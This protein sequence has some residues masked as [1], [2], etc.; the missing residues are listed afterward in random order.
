MLS[1]NISKY[2]LDIQYSEREFQV[3]YIEKILH[4][5]ANI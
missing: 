3:I 2:I 5:G 4:G 1:G